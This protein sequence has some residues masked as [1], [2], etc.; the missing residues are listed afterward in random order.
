MPLNKSTLALSVFRNLII[1]LFHDRGAVVIGGN[2]H[3]S[4]TTGLDAGVFL[5]GEGESWNISL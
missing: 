5:F 3:E 1:L 4:W 2:P